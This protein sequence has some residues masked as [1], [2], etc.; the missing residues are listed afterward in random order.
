MFIAVIYENFNDVNAS[1]S[2]SDVLSL[3]RKDIKAFINTWAI[4]C[5]NGEHYM[6]TAKFPAFLQELPP[7]LGYGG[8]NIDN[9]K[10]NKIIYCLNIKS[11]KLEKD[12]EA[13]VYF[14][15]VM[16]SIFHSIIGNN[17]EKVQ[18]CE[19]VQYIMRELRNKY[20]GLGKTL[21]VDRLCGNKYYKNEMTVS[22]YLVALQIYRSWRCFQAIKEKHKNQKIKTILEPKQ[23]QFESSIL[24][25]TIINSHLN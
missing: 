16:W 17:E 5:P 2:E 6:K 22:K 23:L 11:H 18:K 20:K 9:S 24:Q 8:I 12:S 21:S 1:E 3:R 15:E 19:Q 10:L 13:V 4:F 14:P 25:Q 7:P